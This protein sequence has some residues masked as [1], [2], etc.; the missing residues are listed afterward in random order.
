MR[1]KHYPL[2]KYILIT[3]SRV[4]HH[5][6]ETLVFIIVRQSGTNKRIKVLIQ[7]PLF[8]PL[9]L[10]AYLNFNQKTIIISCFNIRQSIALIFIRP[11]IFRYE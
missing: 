9:G 2:V 11:L 4:S 1:E 7:F 8:L 3:V 5:H 10:N 6:I